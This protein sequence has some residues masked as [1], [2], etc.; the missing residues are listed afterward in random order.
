MVKIQ[1]LY[2]YILLLLLLLLLLLPVLSLLYHIHFAIF[3]RRKSTTTVGFGDCASSL[4]RAVTAFN[5]ISRA[6]MK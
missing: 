1:M 5:F 4:H 3:T 2:M 6:L